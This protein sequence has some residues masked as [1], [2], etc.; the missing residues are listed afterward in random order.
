MYQIGRNGENG[1]F[2]SIDFDMFSPGLKGLE[3]GKSKIKYVVVNL[4]G[5]T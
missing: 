5:A 2:V 1:T 4:D 3:N